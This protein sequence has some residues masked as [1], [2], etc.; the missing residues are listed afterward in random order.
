MKLDKLVQ[1]VTRFKNETYTAQRHN[2]ERLAEGQ[3]PPFLFI[4]CSDSRIDPNRITGTD[5]GE[6]FILRN[7]G[8]I[9]P[10]HGWGEAG[11]EAVIE[12]AVVAL[13]VHHVIVCGH[14]NCGAM[15]GLLHPEQLA[16][17]PS[18]AAW[19]AHAEETKARVQQ[20]HGHLSGKALLDAT[21]R[22]NVLVQMERV[23]ALPSV[24]PRIADGSLQVHG[25]VYDIGAGDVYAYDAAAD[26]FQLL[27]DGP[28][29]TET[30]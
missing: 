29:N 13:G 24:A 30:A 14:S 2:F 17:V 23:R 10:P 27:Y 19:L 5:A 6:L 9:V 16:A 3:K 15:K 18:V 21:I 7:I 20:K 22:E 4:T 26:Q 25:W 11:A 12:Y 8:N 1:G 28:P